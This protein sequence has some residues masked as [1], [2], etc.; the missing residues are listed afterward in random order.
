M[1]RPCKVP[2]TSVKTV[3]TVRRGLP[4]SGR[5]YSTLWEWMTMRRPFIP[6]ML[7]T[8]ADREPEESA[9]EDLV[10]PTPSA[11]LDVLVRNA[12]LCRLCGSKMCF[13]ALD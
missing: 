11:L 6:A 8:P 10:V 3:L 1:V 12:P 13:H 4:K 2:H 9:T 7:T 5:V